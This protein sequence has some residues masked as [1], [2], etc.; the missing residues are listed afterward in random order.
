MGQAVTIADY[1]WYW[2]YSASENIIATKPDKAPHRHVFSS[3]LVFALFYEPLAVERKS[4]R[5]IIKK[6]FS[7]CEFKCENSKSIELQT[8]FGI[9]NS[10]FHYNSAVEICQKLMVAKSAAC[11]FVVEMATHFW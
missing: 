11:M 6:G 10:A 5:N 1:L 7:I 2:I 8:D 3:S 4:A 9:E